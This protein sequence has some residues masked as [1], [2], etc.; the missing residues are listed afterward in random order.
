LQDTQGTLAGIATETTKKQ[1]IETTK[2]QPIKATA[3][4]SPQGG[5]KA[6]NAKPEKTNTQK[7]TNLATFQIYK[8]F[9][10]LF[11]PI[12]NNNAN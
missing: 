6:R 3:P 2:K 8:L 12:Q 11:A 1:P 7:A 4:A 9:H 10:E 5:R